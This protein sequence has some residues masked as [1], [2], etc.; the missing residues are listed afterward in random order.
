MSDART[1]R[2]GARFEGLSV[3]VIEDETLV[4]FLVE[5]MLKELGCPR[6]WHAG[7]VT[8]AIDVLATVRP[9]A[10]VLDLNLGGQFAFPVAEALQSAQIPFLFAT[11]YDRGVLPERWQAQPLIRKPFDLRTLRQALSRIVPRR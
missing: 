7:G 3:L 11:G 4:A 6:V 10:A 9:D 2:D 8:E 5:D 1:A